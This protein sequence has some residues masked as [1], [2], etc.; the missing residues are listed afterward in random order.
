L[1]ERLGDMTLD[2]GGRLY[3]AKD[4]AMTPRQF[5]TFYPN[6]ENFARFRDP[7]I[8]SSFWERVTAAHV[9]AERATGDYNPAQRITDT[10][11]ARPTV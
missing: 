9:G 4:A 2:Y 7:M 6:W 11:G 3:P 5:Q 1:L 10:T 8:T